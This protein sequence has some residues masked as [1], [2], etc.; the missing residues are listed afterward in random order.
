MCESFVLMDMTMSAAPH[1][2]D[3]RPGP[4]AAAEPAATIVAALG[5]TGAV[6]QALVRAGYSVT[7]GT[8]RHWTVRRTDGRRGPTD[9]EIPVAARACI[10]EIARDHGFVLDYRDF[11]SLPAGHALTANVAAM[12]AAVAAADGGG[13][14]RRDRGPSAARSHTGV[15]A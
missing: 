12:A 11:A 7:Q 6:T 1:S 2:P 8:V 10:I 3:R 4:R 9:G 5:G 15:P 13:P 14:P